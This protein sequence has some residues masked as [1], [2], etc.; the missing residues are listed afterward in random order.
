MSIRF[1]ACGG[2]FHHHVPHSVRFLIS[3]NIGSVVFYFLNE[4]M[5]VLLPHLLMMRPYQ[6]VTI[7]TAWI[8]SYLLSIFIQYILHAILVYGWSTSFW[9]GLLSTYTGYSGAMI[10]SIPI[11][12]TL[13]NTVGLH[14]QHAW[15]GTLIITGIANFF[16]LNALLGKQTDPTGTLKRSQSNT[17]NT[18]LV[19]STVHV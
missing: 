5:V 12:F 1:R 6:S 13:V 17:S 11:N 2:L 10:A 14:A 16:V 18:T 8:L 7:T 4:A 15:F 3:A 9:A 19:Q